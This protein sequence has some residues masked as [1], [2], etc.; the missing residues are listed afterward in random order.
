MYVQELGACRGSRGWMPLELK[1]LPP[2]SC[3]LLMWVLNRT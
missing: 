2:G 3:E 1:S